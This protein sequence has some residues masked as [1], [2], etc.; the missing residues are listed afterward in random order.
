MR[1]IF[2]VKNAYYYPQF[3][4][5]IDELLE[6][7]HDCQCV[8]Y[9]SKNDESSLND[10]FSSLIIKAVWVKD[11]Q[12]ALEYFKQQKADWVIF[13]NTFDYLKELHQFAKSAQLWHGIGPKSCYYD[14]SVPAT[15]IRFIEGSARFEKIKNM[16]PKNNFK[17]VGY[18][19][20]DPLFNGK[21]KGLDFKKLGLDENK[22]T[23][24]YAP[25]FNP[26]SIECFPDDW[27]KLFT[28][29]NILIKAHA[30]TWQRKRYKAQ[31]IKLD[32]W[33][34][35]ENVYVASST[36]LSLLPFMQK[37][38]CLISEASS[39]L[40]EFLALE[41]PV[42]VCNFLKLSWLYRGIFSYRFK[43]RFQSIDMD[44]SDVGTHINQFSDLK[45]MV[46]NQLN[47]MSQPSSNN[48]KVIEQHVGP[49][50]GKVSKRIVDY[51]ESIST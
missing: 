43:Q 26:S 28:E 27:P 10:F 29:Y 30:F 41:R 44:Y 48:L 49:T 16:Y 32:L 50:D 47:K 23:L 46:D 5:V 33:A 14:E 1:F 31:R 34:K 22:K 51:I 35:F 42:I 9:T 19:K 13:G 45:Q 40:Y 20:L 7:G 18:S 39:T 6:R 3:S 12:G 25:T 8:V 38:D 4:P 21:E 2:D 11:E 15:T 36:E 24:L 17:W 37:A